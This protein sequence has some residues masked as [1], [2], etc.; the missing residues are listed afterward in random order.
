MGYRPQTHFSLSCATGNAT[1]SSLDAA[2]PSFA[3]GLHHRFLVLLPAV[4]MPP[5]HCPQPLVRYCMQDVSSTVSCPERP[6]KLLLARWIN[7][8][9]GKGS[10]SNHNPSNFKPQRLNPKSSTVGKGSASTPRFIMQVTDLAVLQCTSQS[11]TPRYVDQGELHSTQ[12]N[13]KN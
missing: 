1:A 6:C 8:I 7:S 11:H 5:N 3:T 4:Y 12:E 10:V 2:A 13:R 9:V